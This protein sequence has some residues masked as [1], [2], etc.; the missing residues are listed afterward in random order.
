MPA[1]APALTVISLGFGVQSFCLAA[2]SALGDLPPVAFALHADTGW[3]REATYRFAER[4]TPWLEVTGVRVVT[5]EDR[6]HARRIVVPTSKRRQKEFD[7]PCY[8]QTGNGVG[9]LSRQCTD[10]WKLRPMRRSLSAELARRGLAKRPGAV[11]EWLGISLDEWQRMKDAGVQW[12]T[13]RWP[14]V[15]KRM[16]RADCVT[17]LQRHGLEVPVKSSCT[18][19]PF[20]RRGDW[21]AMK[22]TDGADWRQ[23]VEVDALIR[24]ACPPHPI[25]VHR[26]CKPLPEAVSILEDA[27]A[28]QLTLDAGCDGGVC[29]V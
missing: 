26:A 10:D 18:F 1:G 23:A 4:W 15:E 12:I 29:F 2:M 27:G 7:L 16:S 8:T 9:Q 11:E 13:R 20:H 24:D 17:W 25:Y 3:E 28:E 14:L 22:R 5:V 6:E 21:E 19:C